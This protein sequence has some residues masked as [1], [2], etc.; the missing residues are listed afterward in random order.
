M[1]VV[2]DT[3]PLCYLVVLGESELLATLFQRVA[4]PRV[5]IDELLAEAT[6]EVA[7][8]WAAHPPAWLE[9]HSETPAFAGNL[10][11]LDAGECA[12]IQLAE[13]LGADV[14]LID[15][16]D[17]RKIAQ[18]RGLAVTGLLG[19]LARAAR[20]G[21]IVFDPVIERLRATNF[22]MSDQ[23]IEQARAISQQR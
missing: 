7:R 17:G 18:N 14:L 13:R 2:S 23:L 21:L 22:R 6:P 5:V 15:E 16:G 19:V 9:I 10:S 11:P 4:A 20:E 12:A 3:S 8:K 1:I